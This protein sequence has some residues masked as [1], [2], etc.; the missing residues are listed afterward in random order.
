MHLFLP[1]DLL[2]RIIHRLQSMVMVR[3]EA[4]LDLTDRVV[5]L[6]KD[7]DKR[8][9]NGCLLRKRRRG[10][11]R[12]QRQLRISPIAALL[13]APSIRARVH[14]LPRIQVQRRTR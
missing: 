10:Y 1:L 2:P 12:R 8:N 9:P 5:R 6:L 11:M 4:V 7:P 14:R 3:L 13:T